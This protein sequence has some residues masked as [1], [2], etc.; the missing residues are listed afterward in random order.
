M[1]PAIE[2]FKPLG[3]GTGRGRRGGLTI[4]TPATL[5]LPA[6]PLSG[7]PPPNADRRAW[8]KLAAYAALPAAWTSG[9]ALGRPRTT[10]DPFPLGVAS[11]PA[12]PGAVVLWTRVVP[13]VEAAIASVSHL[14]FDVYLDA[15]D[16]AA[17]TGK[18]ARADIAVRWE[19]A[20]D[21]RFRTIVRRG[22]ATAHAALGHSVHVE[23][24]GLEDRWYWFRFLHGDAASDIGRTRP[25]RPPGAGGAARLR[26]ALASCQHY[27]HG[28]FGAYRHMRADAPDV[29]VFV[30]DY[31]Y[32][33]GPR[34]TRM[35]PHPFPS[36]RT[37]ADYRL[38]HALY[39][40]DPDLR[41]MH[42]ASPWI[43]T[44]D[45]HE[46][47]ND[48]A[49]DHGENPGVDGAARR[50]AAYQAYYE[51]MPL[52]ASALVAR[53]THVRLYRRVDVAGLATFLVLDDRQY[54]DRQACQRS[55]RGGSSTIDATCEAL[56]DPKRT[57]LGA[58]QVRWLAG[59]FAR[60]G[61]DDASRWHFI[62]QQTLFSELRRDAR[63]QRWW[64]D[65]WDGYP[66]ERERVLAA[67]RRHRPHNPVFLGGDVHSNY[68]C[69]VKASFAEGAGALANETVATE[70]CGTS[71]SS[72]SSWTNARVQ[73]VAKLNP[74]VRLADVERRGYALFDVGPKS[75]RVAL[76]TID[77]ARSRT[78]AL[79]TLAT[80][81]VAAGRPGAIP[82]TS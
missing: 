82:A 20:A 48:Y 52:P 34:H 51:H 73:R 41:A 1:G 12:G 4:A 44:W 54:R 22:T 7:L 58:E 61:R 15:R 13:G 72:P 71:I 25:A 43:V 47:S 65:G 80:F 17:G 62:A 60:G 30:G 10:A 67:L 78:P 46:V 74:H 64:S 38:R 77:D 19:L 37:L 29:V 28:W 23:L 55:G 18:A 49:G 16:A 42:A 5:P 53:F 63:P 14:P 2:T 27:E 39:K 75:L 9:C 70:F 40:L 76:R 79:D 57:L 31:I 35:R 36:A 33:G 3:A 21:D 32:E 59:E 6:F 24:D 11:A 8:L 26:F 56:H 81:E 68:V 45:D 69:D 50:A 66:A